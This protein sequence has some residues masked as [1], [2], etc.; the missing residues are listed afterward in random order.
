MR[1]I[2]PVYLSA[3]TYS[4]G[5]R[6]EC[7]VIKIDKM[8][9]IKL[10]IILSLLTINGIKAQQL[11][12]FIQSRNLQSILNPASVTDN[13]LWRDQNV[14]VMAAYRYQWVGLDDAPKTAVASFNFHNPSKRISWGGH[15]MNDQTGPTSFTSAYGRFAYHLEFDD[16]LTLSLGAAAGAAQYRVAG[17]KLVFNET[18]DITKQN[19]GRI[20]PD[21]S[22]GAFLY[23]PRSFYVG[24]SMPQTLG[25]NL[26]FR[27]TLRQYDI[28]R[29]QHYFGGGGAFIKV[30]GDRDYIE[31]S[32]WVRYAPNAP[33]NADL[34]LKYEYND[35]WWVALGGS[36]SRALHFD[37]GLMWEDS[38]S[39]LFHFGYGMS[40]N[41]QQYGPTFGFTHELNLVYSWKY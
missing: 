35:T 15:L 33:L 25:L 38:R 21:F 12:N 27:N 14:E 30:N 32:M 11:P 9:I 23:K 3:A 16:E 2:F 10:F 24:I 8:R 41:F 31:P 29:V 39:N 4:L 37:T 22:A 13:Y 7:N 34:N 5:T 19:S 1:L 26:E 36:T 40:Y 18:G 6:N 28:K 17:E 20:Y